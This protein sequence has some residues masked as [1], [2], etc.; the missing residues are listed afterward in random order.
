MAETKMKRPKRKLPGA[1][2]KIPSQAWWLSRMKKIPIRSCMAEK[3]MKRPKRKL[4]GA[5]E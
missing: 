3:K 2:E 1:V 5:V 4:P